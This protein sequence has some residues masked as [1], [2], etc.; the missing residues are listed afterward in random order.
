MEQRGHK[1]DG[2]GESA[3]SLIA[4][5][6]RRLSVMRRAGKFTSAKLKPWTIRKGFLLIFIQLSLI[7]FSNCGGVNIN[8]QQPDRGKMHSLKLLST[9]RR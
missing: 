3:Q 5:T 9:I 2:R 4:A 8:L 1:I 6:K 7:L